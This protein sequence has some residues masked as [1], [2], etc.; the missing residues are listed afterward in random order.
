M[1]TDVPPSS[2]NPFA[3]PAT[4]DRRS[5]DDD[6]LPFVAVPEWKVGVLMPLTFGLYSMYWMFVQY[7]RRRQ[8]GADIIPWARALFQVFFTHRLMTDVREE[9]TKAGLTP[10]DTSSIATLYV[11]LL[12][13]ENVYSRATASETYG[14]LLDIGVPVGIAFLR[15]LV[16]V[17]AQAEMNRVLDHVAPNRDRGERIGAPFIVA[18]IV[19][20]ALWLLILVGSMLPA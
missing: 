12:I 7:R 8:L 2:S 5:L 6:A 14:F 20:G 18:V 16:L 13:V 10:A 4:E 3:P 9:A 15:G 19:F 17:R 1:D 11:V